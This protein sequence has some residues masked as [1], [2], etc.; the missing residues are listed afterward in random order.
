MALQNELSYLSPKAKKKRNKQKAYFARS[1]KEE[2]RETMEKLNTMI[3]ARVAPNLRAKH[4]TNKKNIKEQTQNIKKNA[5]TTVPTTPKHQIKYRPTFKHSHA[6]RMAPKTKVKA[7]T[8]FK[9][10]RLKENSK[11]K[12]NEIDSDAEFIE[13]DKENKKRRKVK[14]RKEKRFK[15]F[16]GNGF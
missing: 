13:K 1:A 3:A 6:F 14:K 16:F 7:S 8:L 15:H 5:T 10:Q 12:N 9:Y 4:E 11:N 2:H